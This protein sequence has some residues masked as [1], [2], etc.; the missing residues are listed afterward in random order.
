MFRKTSPKIT[1]TLA[2][3]FYIGWLILFSSVL[4]STGWVLAL[5][6]LVMLI[7]GGIFLFG[8]FVG[9]YLDGLDRIEAEKHNC[10]CCS[11]PQKHIEIPNERIDPS[12]D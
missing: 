11:P 1:A 9:E 4:G 7:I 3:I 8:L 6:I 10:E 5:N 12:F 2:T